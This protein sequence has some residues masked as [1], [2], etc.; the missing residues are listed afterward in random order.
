[1][2]KEG[3]AKI[4][5]D[6]MKKFLIAVMLGMLVLSCGKKS[7]P[8]IDDLMSRLQKAS[9]EEE[10][11]QLLVP[12]LKDAYLLRPG[13]STPFLQM[14]WEWEPVARDDGSAEVKVIFSGSENDNARGY[15]LLMPL[16]KQ[17]EN[18]YLAPGKSRQEGQVMTPEE[19]LKMKE[20]SK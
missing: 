6:N 15:S 19:Y 10:V 16:E 3:N 20:L 17:G 7:S 12:G 13:W 5:G 18:W 4:I 8:E 2:G 9:S 11:N 14:Q 1:M